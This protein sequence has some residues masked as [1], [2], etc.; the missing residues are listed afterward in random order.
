[1]ALGTS[2]VSS[3]SAPGMAVATARSLSGG[4]NVATERA[5]PVEGAS[6]APQIGVSDS[7]IYRYDDPGSFESG[8]Q[9]Q[10]QKQSGT[11][12][13]ARVS[14]SYQS[15]SNAAADP[16]EGIFQSLVRQGIGAYESTM[17]VTSPNT[18]R[19]GSVM[20]YLF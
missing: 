2:K 19:P 10:Q 20:N 13:V 15:D 18:T 14:A 16:A 5:S 3:V 8:Q 12:F 4:R 1:M 11:P 6:F 17:R 9:Q 7:S